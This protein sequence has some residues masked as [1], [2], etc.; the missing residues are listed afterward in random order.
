MSMI[1]LFTSHSI[2]CFYDISAAFSRLL[3]MATARWRYCRT[4]VTPPSGSYLIN[5]AGML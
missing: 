3:Q 4:T 1:V 2:Y 5:T